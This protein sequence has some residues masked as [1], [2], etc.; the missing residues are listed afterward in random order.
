MQAYSVHYKVKGDVFDA[1]RT[2][3]VDA[4]DLKSAR[5]KIARRHGFKDEK[6]IQIQ[7]S[8]IV[9]YF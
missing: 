1:L 4:K 5:K 7:G 8:S 3:T 9:G 2:L 6:R